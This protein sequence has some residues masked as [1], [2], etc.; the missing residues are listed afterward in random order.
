MWLWWEKS[1]PSLFF[2]TFHWR[3]HVH[4]CA[5]WIKISRLQAR[6][7][8]VSTPHWSRQLQ[9]GT[10]PPSSLCLLCVMVT[11]G[12]W[13][14]IYLFAGKRK[15][16]NGVRERERVRRRRSDRAHLSW[17]NV[18]WIPLINVHTHTHTQPRVLRCC[19]PPFSFPPSHIHLF[20]LIFLPPRH[21]IR[22]ACYHTWAAPRGEPSPVAPLVAIIIPSA[23][24]VFPDCALGLSLQG[25]YSWER[26]PLRRGGARSGVVILGCRERSWEGRRGWVGGWV[27]CFWLWPTQCC[28]D[29]PGAGLMSSGWPLR[30]IL[31]T[32]TH[33]GLHFLFALSLFLICLASFTSS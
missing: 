24:S 25:A 28:P 6:H 21:T 32:R 23:G 19:F 17:T 8:V 7:S 11:P 13:W 27:A 12:T 33:M 1:K 10:V 4:H 30:K 26:G 16:Q 22:L 31:L 3:A 2:L 15:R 29:G 14:L 18:P 5:A 9:I 20:H